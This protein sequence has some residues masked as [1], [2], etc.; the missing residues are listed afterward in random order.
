MINKKIVAV[1]ILLSL[2]LSG[3][4]WRPKTIDTVE[5][6]ETMAKISSLRLGSQVQR[7]APAVA[8]KIYMVCS[9]AVEYLDEPGYPVALM[10]FLYGLLDQLIEERVLAADLLGLLGMVEI[11][12]DIPLT[13]EQISLIKIIAEGLISG[14]ELPGGLHGVT[15]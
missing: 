14:I 5:T 2:F 7:K 8:E 13:T 11:M 1:L 15:M 3:F 6:T 10:N 12:P 9:V 4:G